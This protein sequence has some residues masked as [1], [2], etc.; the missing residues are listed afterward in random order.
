MTGEG[1][2]EMWLNLGDGNLDASVCQH[3]EHI[4]AAIY[5]VNYT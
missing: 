2:K 5:W 3:E 4:L 1:H